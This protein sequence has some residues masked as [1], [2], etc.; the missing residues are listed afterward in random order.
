MTAHPSGI[1]HRDQPA[2]GQTRTPWRSLGAGAGLAATEGL[3][4]YLHPAIGEVLAVTDVIAPV[5]IAFI[6]LAAILLGSGETV[7]RVFRLL[8]WVANRPEPATPMPPGTRRR[9]TA[10]S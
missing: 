1:S 3:A 10:S 5:L 8:R 2:A 6:L 4:G 9:G 7:E